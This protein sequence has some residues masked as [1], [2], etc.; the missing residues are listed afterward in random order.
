MKISKF[1]IR[2]LIRESIRNQ[3]LEQAPGDAAEE[4]EEE[5]AE[6]EP[7]SD[8]SGG[9]ESEDT[10]GD[11]VTAV[12]KLG[13]LVVDTEKGKYTMMQDGETVTIK[14]P[15]NNTIRGSKAVQEIIGS[16]MVTLDD[17]NNEKAKV[18]LSKYVKRLFPKQGEDESYKKLS[19]RLKKFGRAFL[20]R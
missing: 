3:I 17:Q 1:K 13:K 8:D 16:L 18:L 12:A 19:D 6:K 10:S 9:E 4:P 2:Q 14:D 11:D 5:V 20:N 15:E 7:V